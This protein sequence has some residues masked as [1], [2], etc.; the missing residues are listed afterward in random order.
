MEKDLKYPK[1]SERQIRNKVL[2]RLKNNGWY[3]ISLS[4]KW[5]SGTPDLFCA[6]DGKAIFIELK[7]PGRDL[8]RI[9]AETFRRLLEEGISCYLIN[10]VSQIDLI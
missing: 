9:Q 2:K 10:D 3:V 4:D 8:D 6:R 1:L 7:R 5:R